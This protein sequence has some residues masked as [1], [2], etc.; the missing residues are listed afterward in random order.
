MRLC[1]WNTIHKRNLKLSNENVRVS[2]VET[3][4]N[5]KTKLKKKRHSDLSLDI[6]RIVRY[7]FL[8]PKQ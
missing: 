4:A 8:S 2:M 6:K 5:L 7:R 1:F 3:N